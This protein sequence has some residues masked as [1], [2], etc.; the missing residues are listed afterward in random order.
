MTKT[1]AM[2]LLDQKK[3]EYEVKEIEDAEG[4]SGSQMALKAG[5]NPEEVYKTLV[6]VGAKGAH[7]V[8]VVPVE[9]ELDLK[10]AAKTVGEKSI[11]MIHQ[12]E[13]LPL[14][15]YIHGGCSPV[16]MKK[17]FRTV[18]DKS[19]LSH[20]RIYFSGGKVGVQVRIRTVDISKAIKCEFED[21]VS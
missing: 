10:K 12:K 18:F 21:I 6:T 3:I 20:E 9:K 7:Y 17:F 2:R 15:G 11:S 19:V 1:N 16:G 4:L 14:T 8:F 5:E 13:L